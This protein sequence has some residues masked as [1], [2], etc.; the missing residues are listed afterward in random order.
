MPIAE[1]LGTDVANGSEPRLIWRT[2]L[3]QFHFLLEDNCKSADIHHIENQCDFHAP[4]QEAI[5]ASVCGG[6][7]DLR[8]EHD[9]NV[10]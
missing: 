9:A 1:P 4:L 8:R 6:Q 7:A 10:Q 2:G 3:E 5:E